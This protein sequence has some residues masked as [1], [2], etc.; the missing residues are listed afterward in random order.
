MCMSPR[1]FNRHSLM[2]HISMHKH[3]RHHISFTVI[4]NHLLGLMRYHPTSSI[5]SSTRDLFHRMRSFNI[6]SFNT[7]DE[8]RTREGQLHTAQH[9]GCR[10]LFTIRIVYMSLADLPCTTLQ[11]PTLGQDE[12]SGLPLYHLLQLLSLLQHH[13][14]L[15][16]LGTLQPTAQVREE[17]EFLL[18]HLLRILRGHLY[19][20]QNFAV[21]RMLQH[22]TVGQEESGFHMYLLHRRHM[23]L[24]L[25][26]LSGDDPARGI[27]QL[28]QPKTPEPEEL[29]LLLH[30]L[31]H[32]R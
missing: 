21:C 10:T 20:C 13:H 30:H 1:Q 26:H 2:L 31:P 29:E 5:R 16:R 17:S 24:L 15:V 27:L 18:Y 19:I 12:E 3:Q 4:I 28:L 9:K 32:R 6:S 14:G 7:W 11:H 8:R 22:P 25:L 23:L